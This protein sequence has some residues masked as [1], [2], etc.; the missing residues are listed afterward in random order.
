MRLLHLDVRINLLTTKFWC[1]QH[2]HKKTLRPRL[3]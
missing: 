1:V 3:Q 2:L